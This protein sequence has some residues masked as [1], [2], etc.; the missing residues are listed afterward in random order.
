MNTW[1]IQVD[2]L[3]VSGF[4]C[5]LPIVRGL[6]ERGWPSGVVLAFLKNPPRWFVAANLAI[7]ACVGF[8]LLVLLLLGSLLGHAEAVSKF[9]LGLGGLLGVPFLVWRTWIADQQKGRAR[10]CTIRAC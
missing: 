10:R 3:L 6:P 1:P 4:V 8:L 9:L 2:K 5:G 7:I